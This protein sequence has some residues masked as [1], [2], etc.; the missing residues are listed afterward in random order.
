MPDSGAIVVKQEDVARKGEE[1]RILHHPGD[2]HVRRRGSHH[3]AGSLLVPSGCR[4]TPGRLAILASAGVA[5]PLV[6]PLP[7]VAHIATGGEL[8]DCDSVPAA[9]QIRDTNSPL[10]AALVQAHGAELVR[11]RR[12]DEAPEN[13]GQALEDALA[14][15]PDILLVSGGASVGDHDHTRACLV[16]QRNSICSYRA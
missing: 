16:R 6:S 9:G 2:A 15:R 14:A 5:R 10:L 1:I 8:V 3:R 11:H 13:L 12:V 7:R 4:L